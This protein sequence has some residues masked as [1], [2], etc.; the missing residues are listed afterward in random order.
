MVHVIDKS[1]LGHANLL[2]SGIGI[3]IL[4]MIFEPRIKAFLKNLNRFPPWVQRLFWTD[5]TGRVVLCRQPLWVI[6]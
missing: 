6:F 5:L 3:Q 1:G 2:I 4:D